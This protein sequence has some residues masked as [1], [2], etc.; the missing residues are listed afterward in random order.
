[1]LC[2]RFG[3]LA[4]NPN[5]TKD[6]ARLFSTSDKNICFSPDKKQTKP[7]KWLY[8]LNGIDAHSTGRTTKNASLHPSN[9]TNGWL[10]TMQLHHEGQSQRKHK[11]SPF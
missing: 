4:T 2:C 5:I 10:V 7:P 3:T 9:L 1:M 11:K 6:A 8:F